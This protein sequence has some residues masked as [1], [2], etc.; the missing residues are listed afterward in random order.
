M[1]KKTE[2]KERKER[3]KGKKIE[4]DKGLFEGRVYCLAF[5]ISIEIIRDVIRM[6][7]MSL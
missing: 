7:N 6:M 2:K 1:Q 5:L 4:R 3:K